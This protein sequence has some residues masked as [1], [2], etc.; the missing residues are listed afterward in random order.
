ML[1]SFLW[2]I[3]QVSHKNKTWIMSPLSFFQQPLLW[4][5]INHLLLHLHNIKSYILFLLLQP[6]FLFFSIPLGAFSFKFFLGISIISPLPLGKVNICSEG[7][8]SVIP[9]PYIFRNLLL[10]CSEFSTCQPSEAGMTPWQKRS[11]ERLAYREDSRQQGQRR[12]AQNH[13][14]SQNGWGWKRPPEIIQLLCSDSVT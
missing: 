12:E 2:E 1:N 4:F 9:L 8:W 5:F 13:T 10:W 7:E 3:V 11:W 14:E 6:F